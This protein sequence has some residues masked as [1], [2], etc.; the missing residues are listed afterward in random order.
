MPT[1]S[2]EHLTPDALAAGHI[3]LVDKPLTWTS[4]DVVAKLK[5]PLKGIKI[6]HAGTLDPLATGLLVCCTGKAT[7]QI[8]LIQAQEK[9]YEASVR[10]GATTASYDAEFSPE[11]VAD[12]SHL[13]TEAVEAALAQF[14]GEISQLP[15]VF[16]ALKVEGKRAYD[17]ARNGKAVALQ[18]R[19]ITIYE[20][21]LTDFTPGPEATAHLYIRCQKGTYIRSLAH[22]LGQALGVGGYLTALR[23]TRIGK[24]DVA[25]AWQVADLATAIGEARK[26]SLAAQ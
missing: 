16:S 12:P 15:P 9:V 2:P 26:A 7:K 20:L 8:E 22:D 1:P 11:P 4:F 14:R 6:G 10:L 18:P 3:L 24:L 19:Q 17:L 21:L 25:N 5:G 13:T 23:R